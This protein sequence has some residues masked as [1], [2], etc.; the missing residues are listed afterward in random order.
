MA[1]LA[2]PGTSVRIES[3]SKNKFLSSISLFT[4]SW[5]TLGPLPML[6]EFQ[7]TSYTSFR[8]VWHLPSHRSTVQNFTK[9]PDESVVVAGSKGGRTLSTL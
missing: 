3:S 5:M 8:R 9:Y 2:D 4:R 6:H 7:V 1:E